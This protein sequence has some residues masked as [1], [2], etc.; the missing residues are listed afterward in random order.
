MNQ[1]VVPVLAAA[2]KRHLF[3]DAMPSRLLTSCRVSEPD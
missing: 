1:L 2:P 3:D